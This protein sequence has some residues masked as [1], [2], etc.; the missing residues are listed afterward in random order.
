MD[1]L[2][3]LQRLI[4]NKKVRGITLV[5]LIITIGIISLI[6]YL[7][8]VKSFVISN[9]LEEIE[10]KQI[11]NSINN[12]RNHSIITRKPQSI[13]FN[14]INNN[15]T[16]SLDQEIIKLKKLELN[17]RKSNIETFTFTKNGSP[18]FKGSGTIFLSGEIEEYVIAV[19]PV[20]GKV[21]ARKSD[22]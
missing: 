1:L 21:N 22:E 19:T 16:N 13:T 3:I 12:T 4:K 17:R 9:R 7:L 8:I 11:V 18:A 5:E 15:Y 10:L 20:T 6:S 14:F 2:R